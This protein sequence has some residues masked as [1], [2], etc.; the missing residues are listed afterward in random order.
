MKDCCDAW[1]IAFGAKEIP[2][3]VDKGNKDKAVNLCAFLSD[4]L[5]PSRHFLITQRTPEL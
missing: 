5:Q 3:Y 2:E 1:I 4:I